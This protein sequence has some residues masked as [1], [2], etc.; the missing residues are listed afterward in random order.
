MNVKPGDIGIFIKFVEKQFIPSTLNGNLFFSS[1]TY[2]RQHDTCYKDETMGD[3]YDPYES[4]DRYVMRTDDAFIRIMGHKD[5]LRVPV[6]QIPISF[7][8]VKPYGICS[9][10]YLSLLDFKED[11]NVDDNKMNIV[12]EPVSSKKFKF[13]S[14]KQSIIEELKTFQKIEERNK[15]QK[16]YPLFFASNEFIQMMNDPK[17]KMGHGLVEYHDFNKVVEMNEV[18]DYSK[19]EDVEVLFKKDISYVGQR[20]FRLIK[21]IHEGVKGEEFNIPELKGHIFKS[22]I[23]GL[24]RSQLILGYK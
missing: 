8:T 18:P 16:C 4:S 5:T 19:K 13:F 11:H 2:F 20:E 3:V 12:R 14:L 10:M 17:N 9:F 22:S 15:G 24:Q 6:K 23:E 7:K 21:N 1:S